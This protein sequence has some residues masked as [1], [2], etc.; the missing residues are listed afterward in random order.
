MR[1]GLEFHRRFHFAYKFRTINPAGL[2][3]IQYIYKKN[4]TPSSK[5]SYITL[6]FLFAKL[7]RET[8]REKWKW[9][10]GRITRGKALTCQEWVK[11]PLLI[12][13]G[14]PPTLTN[15]VEWELQLSF[16]VTFSVCVCVCM[17]VCSIEYDKKVRLERHYLSWFLGYSLFDWSW[18]TCS[19]WLLLYTKLSLW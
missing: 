3:Y 2:I 1:V 9:R 18:L 17:S 11:R 13:E 19:A 10:E 15:M 7:W 16:L 6:F 5:S 4:F 12:G 8:Q 14:D